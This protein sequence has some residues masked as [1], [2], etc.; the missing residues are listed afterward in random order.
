M[1]LKLLGE[2]MA[3]VK[4]EIM[5]N[6]NKYILESEDNYVTETNDPVNQPNITNKV[7]EKLL[8]L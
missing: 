3:E 2:N 4:K 6:G 1:I 5:Y 8:K 7:T